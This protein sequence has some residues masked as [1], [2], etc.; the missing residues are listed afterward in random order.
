MIIYSIK[1]L[2][3]K[4]SL[5]LTIEDNAI[6]QSFLVYLAFDNII[7]NIKKI[8]FSSLEFLKRILHSIFIK[9]D[10]EIENDNLTK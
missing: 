5:E 2:E 1:T 4:T 6:M 8:S 10:N 3:N 7:N 9:E